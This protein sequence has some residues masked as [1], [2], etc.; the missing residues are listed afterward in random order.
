MVE[1][2]RRRRIARLR[3]DVRDLLDRGSVD[4]FGVRA[5]AQER[6]ALTGPV[7]DRVMAL[8]PIETEDDWKGNLDDA[9]RDRLGMRANR[10]RGYDL[11]SDNARCNRTVV[12]GDN[13]GR[14]VLK[15]LGKRMPVG[16][17]E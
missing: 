15:T 5:T 3:V 16:E 6:K 10:K 1:R 13:G 17:R 11:M 8:Q 12:D 14:S 7:D 4:A 2:K 9:E